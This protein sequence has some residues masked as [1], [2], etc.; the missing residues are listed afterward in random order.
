M[1]AGRRSVHVV[2]VAAVWQKYMFSSWLRWLLEHMAAWDE[3]AAQG[4]TGR[5]LRVQPLSCGCMR[6]HITA[7]GHMGRRCNGTWHSR[8]WHLECTAAS[9]RRPPS[10][11]SCPEA[12]AILA[13]HSRP[14]LTDRLTDHSRPIL[15]LAEQLDQ[16]A[17]SIFAVAE[18]R[19]GSTTAPCVRCEGC[20]STVWPST[21]VARQWSATRWRERCRGALLALQ[22]AC[23][24]ATA[25]SSAGADAGVG[26]L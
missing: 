8:C 1:A 10:R 16:R 21:S 26:M 25:S 15:E 4:P 19:R 2:Y 3:R 13:D 9:P 12:S 18:L 20:D 23:A 24:C 14:V 22:R 6:M 11:S 17:G 5:A 7:P